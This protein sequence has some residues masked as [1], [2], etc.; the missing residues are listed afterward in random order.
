M[1]VKKWVTQ[2]FPMVEESATVRECLHRMRQYQ[3]NE[4]IVKDR[5]GH[6]RGVVNK[7]DLLDLDLDSSVFNKV[8]LPD[9]FVHEEDNITHAL[10]LFL[11]HQEPYLPVVDEEMRLKG[12]VSLHDFLEALIEALAMDVP[13]IRFSVLLEDK[14]GELRK[15]V[16]ALALSNINILSVITTRSGDGKREVL[17]KVD[18]VDE[19][20]L[21]KLFESLGIKIESIEKEEGF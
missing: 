18:A 15:V 3:T 5:E 17:I 2:D 19:G 1:K 4:C 7:E 9:F 12:A 14:P 11:E 6:F 13:G 10:L 20:T 16:D 21:I 8:S